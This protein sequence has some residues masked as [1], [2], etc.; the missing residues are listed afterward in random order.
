VTFAKA[1]AEW[2]ERK[3]EESARVR[4][5]VIPTVRPLVSGTYAGATT[6]AAPKSQPYRD[7]VLL[8]MARGRPC[9]LPTPCCDHMHQTTVAAHSNQQAHGKG[10]GRKADD[11]Y[12]VWACFGA[13]T[14]L[15]QSKASKAEKDAKFAF[16]H[17]QQVL[18][19]RLIAMDPNEPERFR[20][21]AQRA[22]ERLEMTEEA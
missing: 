1:R 8:E 21:A 10:K 20:R 11:C 5:G 19:W 4:G 14:W 3:A 18:A 9:L 16:A 12:T 17:A 2:L 13:H 15:D 22:L 6:G 7:P